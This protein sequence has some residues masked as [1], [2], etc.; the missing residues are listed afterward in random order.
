[1]TL[2]DGNFVAFL[3]RPISIVLALAC[4]SMLLAA[5]PAVRRR[6][7]ALVARLPLPGSRAKTSQ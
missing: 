6:F 2:S 4:L 7:T 3:N 5:I 1:M